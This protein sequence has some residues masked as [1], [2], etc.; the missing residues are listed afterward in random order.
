MQRSLDNGLVILIDRFSQLLTRNSVTCLFTFM[1]VNFPAF[2]PISVDCTREKFPQKTWKQSK[3]VRWHILAQ[4]IFWFLL[5]TN[6]AD[7]VL[8]FLSNSRQNGPRRKSNQFFP[9]TFSTPNSGKKHSPNLAYIFLYLDF[10]VTM[11]LIWD[12]RQIWKSEL[13]KILPK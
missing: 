6:F 11:C 5:V 12:R 8:K 7:S 13:M 3:I 10:G 2:Q 1:C 4:S 9:W